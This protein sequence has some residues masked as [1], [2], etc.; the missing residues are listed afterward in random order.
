MVWV[1][2]RMSYD[3]LKVT[4]YDNG[5]LVWYSNGVYLYIVKYGM[6]DKGMSMLCRNL[7]Y[8]YGY[9]YVIVMVWHGMIT[10]IFYMVWYCIVW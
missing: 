5:A 2:Y 7:W 3:M 6:G 10:M 9:M 1:A 8:C 4:E